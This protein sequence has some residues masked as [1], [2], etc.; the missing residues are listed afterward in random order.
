VLSEHV[1]QIADLQQ[2]LEAQ[3][4]VA[5]QGAQNSTLSISLLA[6]FLLTQQQTVFTQQQ[7]VAA[8]GAQIAGLTTFAVQQQQ[9]LAEQQRLAG[10]QNA[11][12]QAQLDE[13]RAE[14]RQL[15]QHQP[16]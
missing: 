16:H 8:Q 12:L 9:Q 15:R 6:S 1:Q 10:Q 4:L 11:A 7:V 5:E 3:Q 13:L 14:L 2:Q